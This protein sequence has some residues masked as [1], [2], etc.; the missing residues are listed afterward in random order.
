M[1]INTE[2]RV[3]AAQIIEMKAFCKMHCGQVRDHKL[4]FLWEEVGKDRRL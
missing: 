3:C 1:E 2:R 4:P